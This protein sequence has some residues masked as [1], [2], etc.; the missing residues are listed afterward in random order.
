MT[1]YQLVE[2]YGHSKSSIFTIIKDCDDSNVKKASPSRRIVEETVFVDRPSLSKTDLGE[3]SRQMIC[4][5]L[6]LNGLSVF[7]PVTEDTPID[8]LIVKKNGTVAKCQCKYIWPAKGK[9]NH[10]MSL[11]SI[12]KNGPNSTAVKHV[13]TKEEVDFFLG[14]CV[15][16][17]G[18]YVIP[19]ECAEG[20][21]QLNLWISRESLGNSGT[22]NNFA[23]YKGRFDLLK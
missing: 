8:L 13:Y 3:A 14:Y 12:R 10:S 17:D 22:T 19:Y 7:M 2:K 18:V 23:S 4:A 15:D 21:A 1:L 11:C 16:D 5:R 9:G 6:M 20:R